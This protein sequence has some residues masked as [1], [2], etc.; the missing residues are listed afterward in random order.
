MAAS[1]NYRTLPDEKK[2]IPSVIGH[3]QSRDQI[4]AEL[5]KLGSLGK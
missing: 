5:A 1:G 2:L 3:E 4:L